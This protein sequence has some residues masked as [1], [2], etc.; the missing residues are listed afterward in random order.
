MMR[1][2]RHIAALIT[3]LAL[4]ACGGGQDPGTSASLTRSSDGTLNALMAQFGKVCIANAPGF[5]QAQVS[6]AF[7]RTQAPL[8]A[9]ITA[10]P[11]KSC[12]LFVRGY[13]AQR[14]QP[15]AG[16]VAA[17]GQALQSR[18]GGTYSGPSA[19]NKIKTAKVTVNRTRYSVFA[20][21]NR[22]GELTMSI[23]N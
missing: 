16:D 20:Y 21:V 23:I 1:V 7:N 5:S 18:I 6:A 10:K 17:L 13:G 4:A 15:T 22:K 12:R 3:A 11:G 8:P 19:R 9:L 14:P 2:T